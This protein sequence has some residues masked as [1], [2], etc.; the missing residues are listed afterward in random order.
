MDLFILQP[1]LVILTMKKKIFKLLLDA[2]IENDIKND[3]G[4]TPI[5]ILAN[6]KVNPILFSI[7]KGEYDFDNPNSTINLTS[8]MSLYSAILSNNYDVI[9]ARNRYQ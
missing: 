6:Q 5:E 4:Y 1:T 8:S 2:G 9:K 3:N 7:L